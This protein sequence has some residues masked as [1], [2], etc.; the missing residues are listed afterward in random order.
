MA[1]PYNCT[2][3]SQAYVNLDFVQV[4]LGGGTYELSFNLYLNSL[5]IYIWIKNYF[6][7]Y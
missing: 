5:K 7:K 2:L 3:A 4:E 1:K 6:T